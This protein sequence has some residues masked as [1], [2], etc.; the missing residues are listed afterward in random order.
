MVLSLLLNAVAYKF[1]VAAELPHVP[2]STTFDQYMDA[3]VKFLIVLFTENALVGWP[4]RYLDGFGEVQSFID[5]GLSVAIAVRFFLHSCECDGL[6]NG[7]I[8]EQ[9][10]ATSA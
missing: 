10:S 8:L 9:G 1:A 4:T 5:H 7:F 6:P 2:Y 3:S